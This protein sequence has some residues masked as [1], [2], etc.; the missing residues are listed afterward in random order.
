MTDQQLMVDT[1]VDKMTKPQI[2]L[3]KELLQYNKNQYK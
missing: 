3:E 1:E 2:I